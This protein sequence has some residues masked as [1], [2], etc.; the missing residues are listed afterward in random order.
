LKMVDRASDTGEKI[1]PS[2]SDKHSK[3]NPQ[4]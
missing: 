3:K 2:H 1:P 4:R